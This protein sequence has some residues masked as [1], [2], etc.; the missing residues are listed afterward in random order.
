MCATFCPRLALSAHATSDFNSSAAC[1]DCRKRC[2]PK[3]AAE[4]QVSK[5]FAQS[6]PVNFGLP[7]TSPQIRAQSRFH[8]CEVPGSCEGGQSG[9][10]RAIHIR[11]G[12]SSEVMH[13]MGIRCF[14]PPVPRFLAETYLEH[15]KDPLLKEAIRYVM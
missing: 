6:A 10:S 13:F 1:R 11:G 7:Y 2:R 9:V 5:G 12:Q 15:G 8:S 3:G 14:M 4:L